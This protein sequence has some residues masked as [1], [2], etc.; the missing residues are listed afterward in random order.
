MQ[1]A[2]RLA[3]IAILP[4][5]FAEARSLPPSAFPELPSGIVSELEQRGCSIPQAK[6]NQ[7]GNVIQGD[8]VHTGETGWAVVCKTR[9]ENILLVF[10]PG[11]QGRALEAYKVR[12][13]LYKDVVIAVA[14]RQR[15]LDDLKQT[16]VRPGPPCRS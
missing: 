16:R 2:L 8:F 10:V 12:N 4:A 14:S 7:R 3:V 9:T 1:P 6:R 15:M 11:A 13:G 5:V